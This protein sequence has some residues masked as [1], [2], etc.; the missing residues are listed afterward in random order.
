MSDSTPAN[1]AEPGL[2]VRTFFVRGRNALVA[3]ANLS[4]LY[5]DYYLH[6]G[7]NGV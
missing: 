7:A 2:E 5:V 4:E 6:L 3:R 1:P